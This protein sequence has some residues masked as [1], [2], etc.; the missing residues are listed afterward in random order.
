MVSPILSLESPAKVNLI[1]EIKGKRPDGYHELKTVMHSLKLAD[2]LTF[3][4]GGQGLTVCCDHPEVPE[5]EANL[6]YRAVNQLAQAKGVNPRVKIRIYKNIPVAAG[7]G[8]GSSNAATALLGCA[9]L[10][11]IDNKP[12][13]IKLA[14]RLGSDVP[15]FLNG[16]CMLGTGRGERLRIWPAMPGLLMAV[17]NPGVKVATAAV[18]K[19][20]NLTLTTKKACINMMRQALVEKNALK[21]G[22]NLFNHLEQVTAGEQPVIGKIKSELLALGATAAMMT[23][24]GATVFGLLPSR[25]VARRV[26]KTLAARY[27][28]VVVTQTAGPRDDIE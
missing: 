10:W 11:K 8:G 23:G 28:F 20:F 21:I 16:G 2:R 6:V 5:G 27:P 26:Q 3:Q 25:Q 1:L 19:K 14:K 18:Y 15:F 17:I 9:R 4:P 13:L 7:M 12:L 22:K 24:S